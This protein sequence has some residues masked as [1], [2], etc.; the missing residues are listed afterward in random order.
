MVDVQRLQFYNL[1]H[2]TSLRFSLSLSLWLSQSLFVLP[3]SIC[4]SWFCIYR[5]LFPHLSRSILS[6]FP[7]SL[8]LSRSPLLARALSLSLSLSLSSS[9]ALSFS[10][11]FPH[12]SRSLCRSLSHFFHTAELKQHNKA[13]KLFRNSLRKSN[14]LTIWFDPIFGSFWFEHRD[15]NA[16]KEKN[17]RFSRKSLSY[18]SFVFIKK[19]SSEV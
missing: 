10:H 12:I 7:L 17:V 15:V 1:H 4:V 3:V 16:K 18:E 14:G 5:F 13:N 11:S 6:L 9:R 2:G 19:H 8:I